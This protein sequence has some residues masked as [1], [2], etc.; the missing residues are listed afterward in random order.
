MIQLT[1]KD[2]L[3]VLYGAGHFDDAEA[4]DKACAIMQAA[5]EAPEQEPF[6]YKNPMRL[7]QL[8]F[9][10]VQNWMPLYTSPPAPQAQKCWCTTCR[11]ITLYDMRFVVCPDCGNKRCPKA[12]NH[13]LACTGSND[14]GQVGSSWE[15]IK[16]HAAPQ[17]QEL[18]Q[19]DLQR[20]WNDAMSVNRQSTTDAAMDFGRAVLAAQKGKK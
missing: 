4:N 3:A 6:I 1:K 13:S 8:S 15:H 7:D 18:T 11:P 9:Q 16:P 17:A 10:K 12:N 20:M 19:P 14:V 2:A 5:I